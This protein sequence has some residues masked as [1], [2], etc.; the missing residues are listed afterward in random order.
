MEQMEEGHCVWA[1]SNKAAGEATRWAAVMEA[2]VNYFYSKC[3]K[4]IPPGGWDGNLPAIQETRVQSLGP[5][6]PLE[7]EMAGKSHGQKSLVGSKRQ[8]WLS[9]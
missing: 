1:E 2:M 4:G 3:N 6:D 7:K 9:D 5:E 8:T